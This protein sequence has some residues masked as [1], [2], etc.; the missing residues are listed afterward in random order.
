[1]SNR[2]DRCRHWDAGSYEKNGIAGR[3]GRPSM[4]WD[5]T[6]WSDGKRVLSPEHAN[7]LMFVQDASDYRA[8]LWT[9]PAFFCAA[10]E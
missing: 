1:M 8:E 3:C 9:R 6:F 7:D 2:C 4:F 10:Y 5:A